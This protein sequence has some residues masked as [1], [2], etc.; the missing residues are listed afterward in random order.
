MEQP[1]LVA[2]ATEL[3]VELVRRMQYSGADRSPVIDDEQ[4]R[5]IVGFVSPADI[6]RIRIRQLPAEEESPF[7]I[8]E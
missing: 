5:K 1:K 3:V 7:E 2:V 4:S 6:L 8:F